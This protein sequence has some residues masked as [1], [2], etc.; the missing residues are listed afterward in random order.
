MVVVCVVT[1]SILLYC[2]GNGTKILNIFNPNVSVADLVMLQ[3]VLVLLISIH[4]IKTIGRGSHDELSRQSYEW[5]S[6]Q[7]TCHLTW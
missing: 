4:V 5:I 2:V 7:F 6:G 3:C 1:F